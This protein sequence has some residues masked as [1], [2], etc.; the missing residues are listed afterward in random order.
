MNND[1]F[2]GVKRLTQPTQVNLNLKFV[3]LSLPRD[4]TDD[5]FPHAL[6]LAPPADGIPWSGFFWCLNAH[7]SSSDVLY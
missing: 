5:A 2:S 4:M 7:S 3:Q 6:F 1:A